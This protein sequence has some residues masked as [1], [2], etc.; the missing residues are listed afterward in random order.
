[1]KE[2]LENIADPEVRAQVEKVAP[3]HGYLSTGAFASIQML[4]LAWRVL[5]INSQTALT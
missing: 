4:N 2:I 5:G 1:M 3:F